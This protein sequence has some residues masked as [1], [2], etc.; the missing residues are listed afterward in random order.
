MPA[1]L[2]FGSNDDDTLTVAREASP[3][4]IEVAEAV[5]TQRGS[6]TMAVDPKTHNIYLLAAQFTPPKESTKAGSRKR[7]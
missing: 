7:Q 3:G 1:G 6:K 5:T 4:K 2:A